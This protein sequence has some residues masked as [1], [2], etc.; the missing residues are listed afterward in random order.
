MKLDT[1]ETKVLFRTD[2]K[3]K[4]VIAIFP[5]DVG[6]NDPS[7]CSC[8]VHNGQ[9]GSASVDYVRTCT[10]PATRKEAAPLARELRRIGYR[11]RFGKRM[12]QANYRARVAQINR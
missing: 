10:R 1:E 6:T 2:R 12:T 8:Y 3:D 4:E 9:H 7:T 5:A 11:L